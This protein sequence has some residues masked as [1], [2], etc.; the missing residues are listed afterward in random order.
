MAQTELLTNGRIG[1][2]FHPH[3]DD[4]QLITAAGWAPWWLE[5]GPGSPDW[6]NRKPVFSAYTLDDGLTQ[7]L[8]TPWGTHE[9][10]LWQQLPSVAGNQYELSVE[11]QAWS[12]EDAAPGSRLEASD[13]NLQIGI[14]P[15]GGLDPTSPLIVWSEVAQPLSRWETLRVQ[16]E[17]EAS[18]ITVFLKSAPNLPKRLQSVFWR[19]AFLRPIGRHKR[20]VNIVGLGDTHI[21]LEPE[22]PRPG[23]PITAV[24]S[25]SREH[26]FA[27]LIVARPDDTWSKVVSKGRTVDEDRFLWRYQFST[28]ID[29]LYDI[30]FVGDFAARL[31]ALRLLQVARNV[32]LVPSD[33]ARLN[34]RRVYVLL[35]PTASQK[36]V[37]AA[38]KGGYDGRFTIGFSADDAGIGNLENR[39]V[40]AV[41]PHHWPEVLTASWF[42]QHYPGVKFTAVVANQ[43]EDLEAWLKNWTGLE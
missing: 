1:K 10:G 41:N 12:S 24:V 17:A 39:H 3:R 5:P 26:K 42:Q 2:P 19:N 20:G 9:A 13:V 8:S 33:S 40:L 35:P 15:T 7:Q 23:E 34:Y 28:D 25:S 38:A 21:S 22:Q 37:L 31:L 29:G 16:A 43:P 11:G 30:R 14:D 27:E 6:K 36:W 4:K 32:Q 18:I